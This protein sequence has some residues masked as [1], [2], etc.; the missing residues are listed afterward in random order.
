MPGPSFDL[1]LFLDSFHASR[2]DRRYADDFHL[3][4]LAR[5]SGLERERAERLLLARLKG[6]EIDERVA[7]ALAVLESKAAVKPLHDALE[8]ATGHARVRIAAALVELDTGFDPGDVLTDAVENGDFVTRGAAI[9]ELSTASPEVARKPLLRALSDENF[10]V[11]VAAFSALLRAYGTYPDIN[12]EP[13]LS[14]ADVLR[15]L[16]AADIPGRRHLGLI[17]HDWPVMIAKGEV[18]RYVGDVLAVVVAETQFAARRAAEI[19]Q[20]TLGQDEY[21]AS[22]LKEILIDLG[23]DF[24]LA[25]T[26]QF[27]Q[28]VYLDLIVEMPDIADDGLVL[29]PDHMLGCDDVLVA[30]RGDI[31]VAAA[32]GFFQ[33][34]DFIAGHRGLEC[35]NRIDLRYDHTGAEPGQ[36]LG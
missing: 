28:R 23:L 35:A 9:R 10:S 1:Q 34:G 19:D 33:G 26:R 18:T 11:R 30:C 22:V 17:V 8:R 2:T 16:T 15:V 13:A 3:G 27:T 29:H 31:D 7:P 24:H 14:R 25:H 36:R 20:P 12:G 6:D 5:L 4:A 32:K 21:G